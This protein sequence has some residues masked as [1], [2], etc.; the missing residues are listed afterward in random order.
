MK[1]LNLPQFLIDHH[2]IIPDLIHLNLIDPVNHCSSSF[3][4]TFYI[5]R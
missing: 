1:R 5:K 4:Q 3:A 2:G